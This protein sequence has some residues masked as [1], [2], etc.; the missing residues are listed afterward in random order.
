LSH[1]P[2]VIHAD[3]KKL[4]QI[5]INL[6]SNAVKLTKQGGVTFSVS[7]SKL[8]E[9]SNL[10]HGELPQLTFHFIVADTSVGIPA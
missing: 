4:R 6:L 2:T 1:L 8:K 9:D 5:I 7:R 3:E 10:S